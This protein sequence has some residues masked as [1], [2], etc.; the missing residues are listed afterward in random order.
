MTFHLILF[1]KV[2]TSTTQS[3]LASGERVLLQTATV[4]LQTSNSRSSIKAR[5]LLDSASQ[6]T[7]MT[8]QLA[9]RLNLALEHKEILSVSTF[10]AQRATDIL[11]IHVVCFKAKLKDGTF[12]TISANILSHITG[13]IQRSP[14]VQ[15]DLEFLESIPAEKLADCLPDTLENTTI[16]LLIGSDYFWEIIGNDRV[17]LPS[18]MFLI[19]SKFGFV[20]GK[21]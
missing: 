5:V 7:F 6:H 12:M 16:D 9:Q 19:P 18:G 20:T 10:G 21:F 8:S 1:H 13:Y 14:L 3:L 15:K 4:S 11:Y 2:I 17:I